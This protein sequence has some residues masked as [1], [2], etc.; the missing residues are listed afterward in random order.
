[1]PGYANPGR[2]T[3]DRIN[4]W[5]RPGPV[6]ELGRSP[7]TMTTAVRGNV[8]AAGQI[9]RLWRQAVNYAAAQAPTSWTD[10]SPQPG[11]PAFVPTTGFEITRALRYMTRSVYAAA[12]SDNSRFAALHTVVHPHVRSKMVTAPAGGVRNRP[13]VR[14]RL[15]SFGSRVPALNSAV[16]AAQV[17]E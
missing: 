9:R 3:P 15:T 1:M 16:Q 2:E 17:I 12:G 14:N 11:M 5:E 7:G 6:V 8:Q 13:T 10:N 4:L